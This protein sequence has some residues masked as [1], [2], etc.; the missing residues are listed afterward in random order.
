MVKNNSVACKLPED[1]K[2]S[3][4]KFNLNPNRKPKLDPK[5][6]HANKRL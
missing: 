2:K 3:N 1:S 4:L 5:I 6:K